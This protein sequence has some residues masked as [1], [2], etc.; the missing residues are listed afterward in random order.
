MTKFLG[1][2]SGGSSSGGGDLSGNSN[3][4]GNILSSKIQAI[5]SLSG[6]LSSGSSGGSSANHGDHSPTGGGSYEDSF[7]EIDTTSGNGVTL[8]DF[9]NLSGNGGVRYKL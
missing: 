4:F 5:S 7:P 3:A 6:P 1:G 9:D 8:G 2:L